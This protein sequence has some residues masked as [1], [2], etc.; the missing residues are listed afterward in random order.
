MEWDPAV[1][2]VRHKDCA[3]NA[4]AWSPCSGFITVSSASRIEIPD[5][6][7]LE[8]LNTFEHDLR[9]NTRW[10]SF[11]PDSRSL[12]RFSF[13]D[14]SCTTSE[15]IIDDYDWSLTT[16]D[17]QTGGRMNTVS[18]TPHTPSPE[19]LSS[20]YLMDG[21]VIAVAHADSKDTTTTAIST[22]NI[23]S[24]THIYS[25]H[26]SEGRIVASIWTHSESLRFVTVKPGSITVWEVE[27]ASTHTLAEVESLPAPDDISL[28]EAL[29]LPTLSRLAFILREAVLI[30]DAEDSRFLLNFVGGSQSM[31]MTFSSDGRFFACGTVDLEINLW[32]ESPAGYALHR[33]LVSGIDK[34]LGTYYITNEGTKPLLSPNGESV[35][36]SKYSETQLW[37]TTDPTT[38]LSNVPL[39]P[40]RRTNFLLEFLS[41]RSVA[42]TARLGEN[43]VA[44]LD[45]KSGNPLLVI[46][47]GTGI[48][49]LKVTGDAIIFVGEGR[50]TTWNLPAFL[51]SGA[52][53]NDSV[54]TDIQ[55]PSTARLSTL[56][57]GIP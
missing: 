55:S 39:R 54:R 21:K 42:V 31:G 13:N 36:T 7:T 32:K 35:V 11:S 52:D 20:A 40:T 22:Y 46:D 30:W 47:A 12:T 51:D 6:V 15:R 53:I 17:L 34:G 29:F 33:R 19:Y 14:R 4:A 28:E 24:G 9:E 43:M 56:R 49:G 50:I 5:A 25:H 16:W 57:R 3:I 26:V 38:S 18:L 1:A 48:W 2:T 8:R 27:F 10:F 37:R 44:V 45:L 41:G 23:F